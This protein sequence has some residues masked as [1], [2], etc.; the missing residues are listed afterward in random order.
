MKRLFTQR[1]T[2]VAFIVLALSALISATQ[3][4]VIFTFKPQASVVPELAVSGSE[5]API[6][7]AL[8]VA[9]IA[10]ALVAAIA[11]KILRIFLILVVFAAGAGLTILT[12]F[13]VADIVATSASILSSELGLAGATTLQREIDAV[14]LTVFPYATLTLGG[15]LTLLAGL[16]IAPSLH[17]VSSGRRFSKQRVSGQSQGSELRTVDA[18]GENS[19]SQ[20]SVELDR[21]SD[22]DALT[23]GEDPSA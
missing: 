15:I 21:F 20:H 9:A 12:I 19:G 11:S 3:V 7:F 23:D 4:W 16:A 13:T 17:W 1:N 10:S 8:S 18:P 2:L 22:W 5:A 14:T 6:V